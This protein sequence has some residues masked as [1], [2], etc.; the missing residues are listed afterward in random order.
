MIGKTNNF[1]LDSFCNYYNYFDDLASIRFV[2]MFWF[3][4]YVLAL[5]WS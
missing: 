1:G 3:I 5:K 2:K 4:S